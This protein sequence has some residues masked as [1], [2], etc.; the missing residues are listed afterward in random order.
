[1]LPIMM[2]KK[3]SGNLNMC[4]IYSSNSRRYFIKRA[5]PDKG[6]APFAKLSVEG[7]LSSTSRNTQVHRVRDQPDHLEALILASICGLTQY[8]APCLIR[9][10]VQKTCRG[11][12]RLFHTIRGT[13]ISFPGSGY[14]TQAGTC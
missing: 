14:C 4:N 8:P 5:F 10:G 1:M 12:Y 7:H 11:Q 9:S 13:Y 3:S 6:R 2:P